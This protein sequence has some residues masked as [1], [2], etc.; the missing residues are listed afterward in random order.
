MY[1]SLE[2]NGKG[3]MRVPLQRCASLTNVTSRFI[4]A[5]WLAAAVAGRAHLGRLALRKILLSYCGCVRVWIKDTHSVS[6]LV[7]SPAVVPVFP[8]LRSPKQAHPPRPPSLPYRFACA[9]QKSHFCISL[10][11]IFLKSGGIQAF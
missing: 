7:L 4:S 5:L 11:L 1:T 10:S 8:L 3:R 9:I 6:I 2:R